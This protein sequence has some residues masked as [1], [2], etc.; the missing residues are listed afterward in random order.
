MRLVPVLAVLLAS[1]ALHGLA[2]AED[3]SSRR[4]TD[5]GG[6]RGY[7]Y[8][9]A[10]VDSFA[11]EHIR[12]WYTIEGTHSVRSASSR[13][14]QVPDDVALAATITEDAYARYGQMKFKT[15]VSDATHPACVTNG[16][17]GK[18]DVYLMHFT[19][20]DG[21]TVPEQ[22]KGSP[23]VCSGFILADSRFQHYKTFEEGVRTVLPH[24]LFHAVQNAYEGEMDS[25]WSEGSAQW[26][27]KTLA[28][29]LKDLESF[30]PVFFNEP[31]RS[32]DTPPGGSAA[33]YLYATAIWPVFLGERFDA[34]IIREVLEAQGKTHVPAMDAVASVLVNR[35]S[36]LAVEYPT[37]VVWN[38]ATNVRA[39]AGGYANAASY[40]KLPVEEFPAEGTVKGIT[41]GYSSG[42][43][44]VTSDHPVEYFVDTDGER[45]QAMLVPL[46]GGITQVAE[47]KTLPAVLNGEGFV[48]VTGVTA[49]KS[50][51]PYT[52]ST[53]APSAA[54]DGGTPSSSGGASAEE[55]G[56]SAGGTSGRASGALAWLGLLGLALGY[57]V[58]RRSSKR[59]TSASS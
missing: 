19:A 37:F 53:R 35:K 36:S 7:A 40:P 18:L 34:D 17:D 38:T 2:H 4:P 9:T 3:C 28:P 27:A 5:S 23:K 11:T 25:Y 1:S 33:A 57:T 26:A 58:S 6:V 31:S 54:P 59:T 20:A 55:G 8:G 47:A 29:S 30:L 43:Y 24:E 49:K 44:H 21:Q 14:D 41:A 10:K 50:D 12:V 45:N 42:I 48:V 51:A 39:G 56:C 15:P 16:G 46:R 13:G 22:C 32:I 52:L